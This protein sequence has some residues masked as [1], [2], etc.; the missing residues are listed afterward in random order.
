MYEWLIFLHVAAVLGFMVAHGAH[1]TAMW[2]MRA[3]ADPTVSLTLLNAVGS[4]LPLRIWLAVVVGSGVLAGFMGSLWTRG[5]IWTSLAVLGVIWVAMWRYAGA[6]YGLVEDAA[7]R[8]I[9]ARA[10]DAT[11]ASARLEFDAARRGWQTIGMTVVGFGG[12]A[13]ILWLMMF[14]P[15]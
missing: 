9:E 1:I 4:A 14:K 11:D 15:F 12:L 3:E 2:R 13:V 5:W 8:A 6:Y 10:S 7:A